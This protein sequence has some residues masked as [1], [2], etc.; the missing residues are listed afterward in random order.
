MA[1]KEKSADG[2][3]ILELSGGFLGDPEVSDF[4]NRLR[5]L[6]DEGSQSVVADMSRVDLISSAGVGALPT[7]AN[8]STWHTAPATAGRRYPNRSARKPAPN[9]LTVTPQ[10]QMLR[11]SPERAASNP[12]VAA[13]LVRHMAGVLAA[14][15][16][17]MRP[18]QHQA[19]KRRR[20]GLLLT[21]S[22][23]VRVVT[24]NPRITSGLRGRLGDNGARGAPAAGRRFLCSSTGA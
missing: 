6:K 23:P 24:G 1:M 18:R 12:K 14:R 7:A 21:E 17:A 9:M 4:H 11:N 2:V 13:I 5:E 22:E 15:L 20:D 19:S 10:K 16:T 8:P 3:V